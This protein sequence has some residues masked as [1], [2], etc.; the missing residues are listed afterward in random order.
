[1]WPDNSR[2]RTYTVSLSP[3]TAAIAHKGHFFFYH[4]QL[5]GEIYIHHHVTAKWKYFSVLQECISLDSW[6][7]DCEK[8][9][10]LHNAECPQAA[11]WCGDLIA[12]VAFAALQNIPTVGK[13]LSACLPTCK[14]PTQMSHGRQ[15]P[16]WAS[17]RLLSSTTS[18]VVSA[19]GT[20]LPSFLILLCPSSQCP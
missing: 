14:G 4:P 7:G 6:W 2:H 12:Q 15:S 5:S 20:T 13:S 8:R 18:G 9:R 17:G 1:M 11:L 10:T 19:M 16:P 3:I